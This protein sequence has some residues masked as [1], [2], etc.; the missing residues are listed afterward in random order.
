MVSRPQMIFYYPFKRYT[1]SWLVWGH[2]EWMWSDSANFVLGYAILWPFYSCKILDSKCMYWSIVSIWY[3]G[4]SSNL[5]ICL[6]FGS[7]LYSIHLRPKK[8]MCPYCNSCLHPAFRYQSGFLCSL[9]SYSS[10][11]TLLKNFIFLSVV[12]LKEANMGL[13]HIVEAYIV[14]TWSDFLDSCLRVPYFCKAPVLGL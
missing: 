10:L 2:Q 13:A 12:H 7:L 3:V 4:L 5:C 11:H 14:I 8:K 9:H 6:K 1:N